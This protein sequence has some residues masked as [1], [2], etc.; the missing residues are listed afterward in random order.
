MRKVFFLPI[1]ATIPGTSGADNIVSLD[2]CITRLRLSV[3]D[4]SLV[5]VQALKDN[6]AIGVVQLNQHNLQVVIGPQV[7][8]VKDEMAGLMHTVQA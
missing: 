1:L 6:R 3:K 2:N 7:Q 8:S 4:M 5:N